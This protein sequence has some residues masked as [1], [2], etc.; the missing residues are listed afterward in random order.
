MKIEKCTNEK[1]EI[2]FKIRGLEYF[3]DIDIVEIVMDIVE[4]TLKYEIIFIDDFCDYENNFRKREYKVN[5]I[6]MLF[7]YREET[8]LLVF[9]IKKEAKE[10][11]FIE[12]F[13]NQLIPF[14]KETM[15]VFP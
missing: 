11:E 15:K 7:I 5:N 8:G 13:L 9:P 2:Y 4:K 14:I 3:E 1:K 6:N 10:V 12:N